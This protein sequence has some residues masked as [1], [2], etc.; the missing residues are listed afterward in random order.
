MLTSGNFWIGVLV[1]VVGVYG[2]H[3]YATRK[4]SGSGS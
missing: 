3:R 2:Y 1:G 4:A